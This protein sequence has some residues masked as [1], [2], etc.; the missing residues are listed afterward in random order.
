[1]AMVPARIS[2]PVPGGASTA[3][4]IVPSPA[5]V[6]PEELYDASKAQ[7]HLNFWQKY[8]V[9]HLLPLLTSIA[10]HLVIL[11]I[12]IYVISRIV[13]M[14]RPAF[15]EQIIIPD[16]TM[17]DGAEAGGIPNPYNPPGKTTRIGDAA[18]FG[19]TSTI[20]Y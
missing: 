18:I 7:T 11:G 16:A 17:V 19:L 2:E 6:A 1:M 13:P 10:V 12:G 4:E 9:H 20:R 5:P 8:W 3:E 15:Q 14:V